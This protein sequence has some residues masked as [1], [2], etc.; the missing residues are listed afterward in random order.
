MYLGW[1]AVDLSDDPLLGLRRPLRGSAG[2]HHRAAHPHQMLA[3]LIANACIGPCDDIDLP[4]EVHIP[5]PPAAD[6]LAANMTSK[7]QLHC[8]TEQ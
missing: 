7:R 5:V 8:G 2:H 3:C 4:C 1:R 6:I